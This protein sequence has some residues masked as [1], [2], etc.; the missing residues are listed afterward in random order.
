MASPVRLTDFRLA[1][2]L[3][4]RGVVLVETRVNAKREVEF[5]FEPRADEVLVA[6]PGSPEERY[7]ASCRAMH[8]LVRTTLGPR[9][10]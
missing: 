2:F 7:D 8:A 10:R 1:G 3:A 4:A 5:V 9:P 6:F